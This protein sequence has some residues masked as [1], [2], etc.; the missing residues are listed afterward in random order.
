MNEVRAA[1]ELGWV[2]IAIGLTELFATK[3]VAKL[4]GIE[5]GQNEGILRAMGV[6]ELCHGLDIL[7]HRDP[8]PGVWSRV[9]GDALDTGLLGAAAIQTKAPGRFA[10]VA[11]L[12]MA[13]GVADML[14]ASKLTADKARYTPPPRRAR[15]G[16]AEML[17]FR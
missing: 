10:L 14:V 11:G 1:R 3:P 7:S 6:R 8:T 13:I 4:M 15:G 9:A 17:G 2:S 5:N 12:V 16:L